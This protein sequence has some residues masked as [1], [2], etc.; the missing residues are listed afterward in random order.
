MRRD[1]LVAKLL[2]TFTGIIAISFIIIATILSFWFQS[3]YFEQRKEQ[4]DNEGKIIADTTLEHLNQP[5]NVTLADLKGVMTVVSKSL[6]SDILI[7]DNLGYVYEVTNLEHNDLIFGKLDIKKMEEL[8]NG[9]S[10]EER[11][12]ENKNFPGAQYIYYKPIFYNS[13]FKGVIVMLSPIDVIKEPL[14]RVY[15]IIWISAILALLG[16]SFIIY[17]FCQKILISPLAQINTAAKRLA[18]GEIGNRVVINSNDEI[19]ELAKSFNI[20]ADSLEEVE[21]NRREFISN[22]SHEIRSPIT[23]IK[24]FIAGILDG[25][26]PKDKENYYLEIAYNEIQRLTR[27]VNDLLDIS[28]MQAGKLNLNFSEVDING[29]IKNCAINMEQKIKTK[30]IDVDVVLE[31]QHLFV[32]GDRDR[33]IQVVTNLLDNAIKYGNEGGNIKITSKSKGNKVWV[34]IYNNGPSISEEEIKYIWDRFYKSD[35]SRTNKVSTGLGLPIVR[36][37]I[38]QH[39]EDIWVDNRD[40]DYGVT[41]TFT[42]KKVP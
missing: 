6:Q 39:G 8:Q 27:L 36:Q 35:K 3:Y 28:T 5:R 37:I 26:I 17:Y 15:L 30:K 13:V 11:S 23:S 16:S 12:D 40:K 21:N 34:S 29:V 42:L 41:F 38:S 18:K 19:G 1:S 25:V 32:L 9:N 14:K 20:M 2:F 22:V 24:G 33:L 31:N 10:V 4:L 7:T